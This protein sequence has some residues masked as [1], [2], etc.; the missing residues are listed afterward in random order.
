M[1]YLIDTHTF[2]WFISDDLKL[3]SKAK[4]IIE[5]DSNTILISIASLWEISI[6]TSLNKLSIINNFDNILDH[7]AFNKFEILPLHFADLSIHNKLPYFHRDPF[8]RIL[9][10]QSIFEKINI[11]S[12]DAKFDDYFIKYSFGRIW[13]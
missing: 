3:T 7:V 2:I 13:N 5:D 6:K 8:D 4:D 12:C 10:S 9:I 1:R 11:I